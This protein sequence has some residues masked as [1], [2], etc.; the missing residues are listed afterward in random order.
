MTRL[1]NEAKRSVGQAELY[2]RRERRIQVRYRDSRLA[3]VAADDLFS[4]ALRVIDKG[5][6]G[7][8]FGVLPDDP[9]LVARAKATA[10]LGDP[11]PFAFSRSRRFAN[12]H[13]YDAAT[14]RLRAPQLIGLCERTRERVKPALP[15]AALSIQASANHEE[16]ELETTGGTHVAHEGSSVTLAVHAPIEGGGTS[17][18]K[19]TSSVSPF[20]APEELL[21]EFVEW[22]R[23]T[24]TS[25]TPKTGRH[26]V[27]FAP[28]AASLYLLPLFSGLDGGA[29]AKGTSPL[30]HRL[31]QSILS[32]LL[33]VVDDALAQD[34]PGSRAFDDEGTPCARRAVVESGVLKT[35][36]LDRHSSAKLAQAPTGN[37]YKRRLFSSGTEL[38]P[39][40]WPG[41]V[42][43][44]PGRTPWR[45]LLS[46]IDDGLLVTGGLGFHSANYPQGQFSV[47]ALG[48]H[49]QRGRVVGRLER[50][51]I[52]GNIYEEFQ[53]VRAV[54]LEQR[55]GSGAYAP[56][57]LL[58]AVQVAGN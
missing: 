32:S 10:A 42:F 23:W 15:K 53:H 17:V 44:E 56:Y 35:F 45:E 28:E 18:A 55:E 29:V 54:S 4:T 31:G 48:Y 7:A 6:L 24:E 25:S 3:A 40:P 41:Q 52:A 5:R 51:M 12:V 13:P 1:I 27:L 46:Q 11:A 20:E 36:L 37:G 57:V 14:S 19:W 2:V 26:P 47:Q 21:D 39:N 16:I 34:R 58:E 8:A 49:V 50:T 33:T 9:G 43:V 38:A 30:A 22:Y